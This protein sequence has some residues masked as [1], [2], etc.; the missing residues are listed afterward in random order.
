LDLQQIDAFYKDRSG[1]KD[2]SLRCASD[3]WESISASGSLKADTLEGAGQVVMR[4]L[5]PQAIMARWFAGVDVTVESSGAN[6]VMDWAMNGSEDLRIRLEG[7]MTSL[8]LK[9]AADELNFSGNR[10]KATIQVDRRTVGVTLEE[11][12]SETPALDLSGRLSL[13]ENWPQINLSLGGSDVEVASIRR[14]ALFLGAGNSTIRE[15]FDVL[16]GG[17][18]PRVAFSTRG[19]S[20]EDLFSTENIHLRGRLENGRLFIPEAALDLKD[21]FGDAE[22][23]GGTL[24]GTAL[25]ARLQTS[26]GQD[27]TLQL[28]LTGDD[29]AFHL[30]IAVKADLSELPPVLK[31][32]IEDP[33]VAAELAMFEEVRGKADGRLVLGDSL[34]NL[35]ARVRAEGIRLSVQYRRLPF[36]IAISG[37]AFECDGA[38]FKLKKLT[39]SVGKSAFSGLSASIRAASQPRLSAT[40]D[41]FSL[42]LEDF[43]R[44]VKT[45]GPWGWFPASVNAVRGTVRLEDLK[46]SGPLLEP[47]RL[48]VHSTGSIESVELDLRPLP[49][50]VRIRGGD[51]D[52][53]NRRVQFNGLTADSGG[54]SVTGL[55][56]DLD[57]GRGQFFDLRCR[58]AAL[59]IEQL[60]NLLS[61]TEP[62]KPVFTEWEISS[63]KIALTALDFRM[64]LSH[65]DRWQLATT[66]EFNDLQLKFKPSPLPF[67]L[68]A[69]RLDILSRRGEGN[70]EN[71]I[72]LESAG[73][74]WGDSRLTATGRAEW[75]SPEM[76]LDLDL[77][78]ALVEWERIRE[79]MDLLPERQG[80]APGRKATGT[81]RLVASQF[82]YAPFTWQPLEADIEFAPENVLVTVKRAYLCGVST[83][84]TI[85]FGNRMVELRLNPSAGEQ[86]LEPVMVC[87]TEDRSQ[88]SGTFTLESAIQASQH[89]KKLPRALEGELALNSRE[90]RISR[91]GMLAKIFS[92]LNVTEIYRGQV[93]DLGGEG[94]PYTSMKVTAEIRR[95]KLYMQECWVDAPSMG[96]A[97]EG[98]IDLVD[99]EMDIVILVAPFRTVDRIVKFLPV[100]GSVLGGTLVSIP[101]R[102]KGDW[103]NYAVI[104]LSPTAVGSGVMGLMERTL[105]LPITLI[106]PLFSKPEEEKPPEP[107]KQGD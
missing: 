55:S 17:R 47:G 58:S 73:L 78:A 36:P 103:D 85:R 87:L 24:S 61:E 27:G 84:G 104:P 71:R 76:S 34:E 41:G 18:V 102:A 80:E 43:F 79:L 7:A 100:I 53:E 68:Q 54:S 95:G 52:W 99:R 11:L 74:A 44:W 32:V 45:T 66:A 94:F 38:D 9:K 21:V 35:R 75:S 57:W 60:L 8:R 23:S 20:L 26:R 63:G 91:F 65:R 6:L 15:I 49:E 88:I 83:P 12:A 64:P 19:R 39:G 101:F 81:I 37:G 82:R 22:I 28:G 67:H 30:D 10:L 48:E 86:N 90:G 33:A 16:R 56:A 13:E 2:F 51:L 89:P 31:R 105:R 70:R 4:G 62:L 14:S 106:Q 92:L 40:I 50:A 98:D 97:C 72:D 107:S 25:S 59:D 42:D 5:A 46:L 96:L 3:F 77:R 29:P 93:P 69:G 1:R